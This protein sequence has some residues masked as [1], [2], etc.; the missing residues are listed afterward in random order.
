MAAWSRAHT[1]W[2]RQFLVL[3]AQPLSVGLAVNRL[4][5]L[6]IVVNATKQ[7]AIDAVQ[8]APRNTV[9]EITRNSDGRMILGLFPQ[10]LALSKITFMQCV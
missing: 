5:L 10:L 1:V 8:S 4:S 6:I 2:M 7:N 9:S 3:N